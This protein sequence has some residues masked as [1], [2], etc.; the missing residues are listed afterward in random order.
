MKISIDDQELFT[1]SETQKKVIQND[2]CC[3]QFDDDM[4]RRLQWILTHKYT[5]CFNRLKLEWDQKLA[6]RGVKMIPTDPDAYAELVFSQK[7]YKN[8]T[9]RNKREKP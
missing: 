8:R 4:K 9:E 5:Q 1:L 2:I 6:E 3:T 7:D